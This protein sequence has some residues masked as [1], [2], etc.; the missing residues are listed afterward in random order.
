MNSE[1]YAGPARA[2]L[3]MEKGI[4]HKIDL[5]RTALFGE[6]NIDTSST[7]NPRRYTG[8]IYY[9][10]GTASNV[11]DVTGVPL[12]MPT[13]ESWLQTVFSHTGSSES[14]LL[15]A[16]PGVISIFD[17]LGASRIQT[18]SGDETFGMKVKTWLTSHGTLNIVKHRLLENGPT[19]G[20]GYGG[21]AWALDVKKLRFRYLG[22]R[23]TKFLEDIQANDLDGVKDE[24]LTEAGWEMKNPLLHGRIKAATS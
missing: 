15:L 8:G 19:S 9:Y 18:A 10:F 22:N 6:R 4:E 14:R 12:T 13:L 21:D 1:D 17:L 5:E 20:Q 3:R 23:N 2:R 7:D 24:Y 16:A 11:T